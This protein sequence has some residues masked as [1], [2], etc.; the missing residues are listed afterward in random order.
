MPFIDTKT[1][2]KI[3]KEQETALKT[4]FGKAISLIGKSEAWLMLNFES[5]CSMYFKGD[6]SPCA[7]AEV[8]LYGSAS[9][10]AYNA[11]TAKLTELLSSTLSISPSRIY[12]KYDEI[13]YWGMGGHNF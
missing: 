1:N 8:K 5:G 2:V 7:I 11:L 6:D 4:G 3:T 12:V 13:E 9:Q 10:S